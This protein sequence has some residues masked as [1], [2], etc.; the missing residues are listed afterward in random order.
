MKI[1]ID[2]AG[3]LPSMAA[4]LAHMDNEKQSLF[5]NTFAKELV[6]VC[7][8]TY[9]AEIQ[10][11]FVREESNHEFKRFCAMVGYEE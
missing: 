5:F 3:L 11:C 2:M 7:G 10:A 6:S 8:T 1:S 9:Q 4:K